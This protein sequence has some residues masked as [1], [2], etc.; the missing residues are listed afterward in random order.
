MVKGKADIQGNR[1][2]KEVSSDNQYC[3]LSLEQMFHSVGAETRKS[4]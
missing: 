2:I 1:E 3:Y 4:L